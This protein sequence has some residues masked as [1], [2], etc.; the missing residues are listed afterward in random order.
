MKLHKTVNSI[1]TQT[2]THTVKPGKM[3]IDSCACQHQF[4]GF[5]VHF[6]YILLPSGNMSEEHMITIHTF[7]GST[8]HLE[9][10]VHLQLL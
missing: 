1:E 5:D 10:S 6:S 2:H 7:L 8:V 3:R 4:L 9:L